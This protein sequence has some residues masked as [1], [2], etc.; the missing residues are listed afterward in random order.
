LNNYDEVA[1]DVLD[2]LDAL[3]VDVVV[4]FLPSNKLLEPTTISYEKNRANINA[5]SKTINGIVT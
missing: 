5:I 4:S 1:V 2:A 3:V